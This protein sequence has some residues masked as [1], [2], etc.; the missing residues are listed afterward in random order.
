MLY[1]WQKVGNWCGGKGGECDAWAG[2]WGE[3]KD[4]AVVGGM[5][6]CVKKVLASQWVCD[7]VVGEGMCSECSGC[8]AAVPALKERAEQVK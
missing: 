6:W 2:K 1:K 7:P 8:A 5:R 4:D 3:A